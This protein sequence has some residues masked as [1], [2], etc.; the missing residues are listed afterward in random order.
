MK[1]PHLSTQV[2]YTHTKAYTH[3]LEPYFLLP[4]RHCSKPNEYIQTRLHIPSRKPY[5]AP[6]I[7]STVQRRQLVFADV[8]ILFLRRRQA[9]GYKVVN[10]G[11][12]DERFLSARYTNTEKCER[13]H[14]RRERGPR[15]TPQRW[16][17]KGSK[18]SRGTLSI[19]CP[20]KPPA[21]RGPSPGKEQ[22]PAKHQATC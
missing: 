2:Y 9:A 16:T 5:A 3:W 20:R 8:S 13:D 18:Q 21:A 17:T 4:R 15:Q 10:K 7:R 14:A 1:T 6:H 22:T 12:K 19:P 11:E